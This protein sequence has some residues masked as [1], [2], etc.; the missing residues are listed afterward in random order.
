M[1]AFAFEPQFLDHI[2][3]VWRALPASLRGRF[4]VSERLAERAA[5]RGIEYEL[6]DVD[7]Y[8]A[9]SPPPKA[10]PAM[11][12]PRAFCASIGDI[13]V[14]RRLGYRRFAFIE[15]G[16]AQSYTGQEGPMG[17][18]PSYTGGVDRD[19]V[20][21]FMV[22]HERAA[23]LWRQAYPAARVEVVG[24]PRLADLPA[25][26]LSPMD[27]A[28]TVAIS[29]H[30]DAHVTPESGSAIGHYL[31]FL[32]ELARRFHVIG[33]A[34]PKGDWPERMERHYRRAGIEFVADFDDVCRRADVY[35]CDNSST[36]FEFASTGRPV[37]VLNAPWYR[38]N[39]DHGLRFWEAA[40]VGVQVDGPEQLVAG[41][42]RALADG[43]E[44]QASRE[45]ALELVYAHRGRI[46]SELA[47]AA[48]AGWLAPA[49]AVA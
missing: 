10:R 42:E 39:V 33:H 38:R 21:L 13:K 27:Q 48:I 26:Q 17:R 47:A 24:S 6:V 43:P 23:E 45:A 14:A 44:Q 35:V 28:A 19:D 37:V 46:A 40:D 15:H 30:W 4:I 22:P 16:A 18:H 41:I 49:E 7:A 31:D 11:D 34:H 3:P 2:A 8:R 12:G 20:E 29:F 25:R 9:S 36:I 32:P 5:G 1:D